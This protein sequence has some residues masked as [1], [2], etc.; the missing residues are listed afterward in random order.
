MFIRWSKY[1]ELWGNSNNKTRVTAVLVSNVFFFQN[2]RLWFLGKP[3]ATV[4]YIP[5]PQSHDLDVIRFLLKITSLDIPISEGQ[6]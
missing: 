4:A 5:L 3:L 2:D 6:F 1:I